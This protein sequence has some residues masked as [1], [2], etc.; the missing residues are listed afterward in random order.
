MTDQELNRAIQY[1]TA[2]TSYGRDTVADILTTGL[3]EM[4][5]LATQS[6]ERFEREVLLEYVCQWTIKRT[7]QPEPLAREIL[8]Y[9]SRWLDEVY[10]EIFKREPESLGLISDNDDD[11]DGAEPV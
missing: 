6:S 2:C 7:G 1:V 5:T 3:G 8:G 11:D 4:T 10:E 9:A